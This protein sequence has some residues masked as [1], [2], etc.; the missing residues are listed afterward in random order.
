[1]KE[2]GVSCEGGVS[3]VQE[4]PAAAPSDQLELK[5]DMLGPWPTP[6]DKGR[7]TWFQFC[8]HFR[9]ETASVID[10]CGAGA[11][12]TAE[13][14]IYRA[15]RILNAQYKCHRLRLNDKEALLPE[16]L[17]VRGRTGPYA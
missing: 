15:I 2:T 13:S 8:R 5:E 4:E 6:M 17:Q 7:T 10:K 9:S 3:A 12:K 1:M 11:G 16:V 14:V